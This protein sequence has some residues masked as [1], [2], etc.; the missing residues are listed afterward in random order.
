[1]DFQKKQ[2]HPFT[3]EEL[4]KLSKP[5]QDY[6]HAVFGL[7]NLSHK[8]EEELWGRLTPEEQRQATDIAK[9]MV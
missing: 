6:L 1:M 8:A 7:M 5:L 9:R 3:P 2:N 4:E